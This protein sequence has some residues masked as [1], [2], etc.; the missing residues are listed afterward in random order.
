MSDQL[1]QVTGIRAAEIWFVPLQP[2]LQQSVA[3]RLLRRRSLLVEKQNRWKGSAGL[4]CSFSMVQICLRLLNS[5]L[6]P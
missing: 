3:F 4:V 1:A 6:A 2:Y 5:L